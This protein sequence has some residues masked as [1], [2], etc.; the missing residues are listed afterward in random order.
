MPGPNDIPRI[1]VGDDESQICRL[2][3]DVLKPLGYVIDTTQNGSEF[4]DKYQAGP[5][6]LLILD[7][8]LLHTTGLEVVMKLRN[9]GDNV[10]II[11]MSGPS[12]DADRAEPFAFTYRV[13]LLRKPFGVGD[14]RGAVERALGTSRLD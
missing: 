3:R 7:M 1:L 8:V 6:S 12:R 5:Y 11:L 14:L 13:D 2:V 10:P 9:R 4:L